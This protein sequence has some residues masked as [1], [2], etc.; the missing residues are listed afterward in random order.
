MKSLKNT[1]RSWLLENGYFAVCEMIDSIMAEW[2]AE[3]KKTR[4]DWWEVIAGDKKGRPRTVAGRKFP[5]IAAARSRQNLNPC[6]WSLRKSR[7]ERALPMVP[8]QRWL[9]F[10]DTT[11]Q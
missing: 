7:Q 11:Q 2:K 9:K 8:Q 1:A 4:R 3:G 10:N 5:I 6:K